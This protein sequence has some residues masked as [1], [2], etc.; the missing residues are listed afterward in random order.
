MY[1]YLHTQTHTQAPPDTTVYEDSFQLFS[2][3]IT[4]ESG[5]WLFSVL[6]LLVELVFTSLE[7][8]SLTPSLI[9][10]NRLYNHPQSAEAFHP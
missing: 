7:G 9:M 10:K 2:N 1:L 3:P 8:V 6:G 4:L 5:H